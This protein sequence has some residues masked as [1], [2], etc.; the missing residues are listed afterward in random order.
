M[1]I[2]ECFKKIWQAQGYK[3]FYRGI[4][5]S[6]AGTL[7]TVIHLVIYERLKLLLQQ[8]KEISGENMTNSG[9]NYVALMTIACISK[10]I[11]TSIAYPH[12]KDKPLLWTGSD[13]F[14][15]YVDSELP[16]LS[17]ISEVVRTRLREET[18]QRRYYGFFQTLSTVA[19]QEGVKALYRGLITQ[20]IRQVRY[21]FHHSMPY[22]IS[23]Y[24]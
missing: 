22:L 18:K 12:G 21:I 20:V 6:Y 23:I 24:C 9:K 1:N 11:A 7:E 5:A 2:R 3:G 16:R 10:T 19:R 15:S 17:T 8:Q 4:T 13:M 14:C